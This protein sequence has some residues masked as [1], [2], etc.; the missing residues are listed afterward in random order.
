MNIKMKFDS[1]KQDK[2]VAGLTILLSV[3][4]MLFV[5]GLLIFIF[6]LMN[7]EFQATSQ[8]AESDS[9]TVEDTSLV[10]ASESVTLTA[11]D[12][13]NAGAISS[14]T[15]VYNDTTLISSGNYTS[16]GCVLTLD[17]APNGWNVTLE[18][19]TYVYTYGGDNWLAINESSSAIGSVSD[20]YDIFI[21][22]SA[23]VVLILL[24]VIIITAIKSSGIMGDAS[25]NR[26]GNPGSA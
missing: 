20:W 10:L 19:V 3:I 4:V 11:C 12:G 7:T 25:G 9:A 1:L 15:S 16:S 26:S 8:I 5:M 23:M 13:A 22:I 17:D 18:N 14:I 24:T 2:G 21:V 6:V